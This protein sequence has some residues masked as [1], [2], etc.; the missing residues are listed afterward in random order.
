MPKRTPLFSQQHTQPDQQRLSFAPPAVQR[1]IRDV[2]SFEPPVS[3]DYEAWFGA[4]RTAWT[5]CSGAEGKGTWQE[6]QIHQLVELRGIAGTQ[7]Y[8]KKK[9]AECARWWDNAVQ[10]D[11]R[12]EPHERTPLAVFSTRAKEHANSWE[13]AELARKE[14]ARQE[15]QDRLLRERT[16][17]ARAAPVQAP[18]PSSR[19]AVEALAEAENEMRMD[20][21]QEEMDFSDREDIESSDEASD[22]AEASQASNSFRAPKRRKVDRSFN[23]RVPF[24][25]PTHASA[26]Y[27]NSSGIAPTAYP[28][29]A[30]I[31]VVPD[32][33][34]PAAKTFL[35]A[36]PLLQPTPNGV[37]C[38]CCSAITTSSRQGIFQKTKP[39]GW[40]KVTSELK[41]RWTEH[42]KYTTH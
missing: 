4:D 22:A 31:A 18:A 5:K 2:F 11:N 16:D 24:P 21:E 34:S 36:T 38:R 28:T 10:A 41:K 39:M 12:K 19:H 32:S 37:I 23:P 7:N 1:A 27:V 25:P 3:M 15:E 9:A 35:L 13:A 6:F 40:A 30:E 42:A 17:R 8:P 20:A 29:P 14:Q 26:E 33:I